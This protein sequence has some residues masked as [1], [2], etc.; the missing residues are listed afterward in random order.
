[1]AARSVQSANLENP[2]SNSK[3]P[4]VNNEVY[5]IPVYSTT[6]V[7][8]EKRPS[9]PTRC[10]IWD[11]Q[12]YIFQKDDLDLKVQD[13]RER[14]QDFRSQAEKFAMEY[15]LDDSTRP[16]LNDMLRKA[17]QKKTPI[18][19]QLTAKLIAKIRQ[20]QEDEDLICV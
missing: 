1:M 5:D 18:G 20:R 17:L 3:W 10:Q 16:R 2:V 15:G 8:T 11:H 9:F 4:G 13:I 14:I 19:E 6:I 7:I 12:N